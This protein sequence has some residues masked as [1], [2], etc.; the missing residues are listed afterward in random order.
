MSCY[1]ES[2][3][4]MII[5]AA[6]A[7]KESYGPMPRPAQIQDAAIEVWKTNVA[8]IEGRYPGDGAGGLHKT[9][10]PDMIWWGPAE[11]ETAPVTDGLVIAALDLDPR[12]AHMVAR[13]VDYQSCEFDGYDK[14]TGGIYIQKALNNSAYKAASTFCEKKH[15]GG[16]P[17]IELKD[18]GAV[19]ILSMMGGS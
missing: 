6:W 19:S 1:L 11:F 14:T 2:R 4:S 17:K 16:W 3:D 18:S 15:G 7:I 8:S 12:E 13:C 10:Y 5:V 9:R